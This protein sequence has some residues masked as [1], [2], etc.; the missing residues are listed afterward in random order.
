MLCAE[1]ADADENFLILTFIGIH[2][3][4]SDL[5]ESVGSCDSRTGSD[6]E[7]AD[8]KNQFRIFSGEKEVLVLCLKITV[9][10]LEK[11]FSS[12][13][14][15][16]LTLEKFPF[17]VEKFLLTLEKSSL[18]VEKFSLLLEKFALRVEKSLSK[19][20]KFVLQREDF[21]LS[22]E[23]LLLQVENPAPLDEKVPMAFVSLI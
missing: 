8:C 5:S 10:D 17:R 16:S 3:V 12:L 7:H 20:E 13:E 11:L 14:K 15:S 9:P 18:H 6:G 1:L 22:L 2:D 21:G 4:K 23:K 19:R